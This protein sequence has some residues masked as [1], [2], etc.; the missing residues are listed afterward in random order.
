MSSISLTTIITHILGA[1]N[2]IV[3]ILKLKQTAF[4]L[5]CFM[6]NTM[7]ATSDIMFNWKDEKCIGNDRPAETLCSFN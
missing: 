3:L 1:I 5:Y 2:C 4:L 6:D 7:S